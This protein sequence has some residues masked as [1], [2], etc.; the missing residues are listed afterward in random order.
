MHRTHLQSVQGS[1]NCLNVLFKAQTQ[2]HMQSKQRQGKMKTLVVLINWGLH[3]RGEQC[4]FVKTRNN[5]S[6]NFN[7]NM[8]YLLSDSCVC[9]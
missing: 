9:D 2:G 6:C 3:G 5:N 8:N 4:H 1:R 7:N